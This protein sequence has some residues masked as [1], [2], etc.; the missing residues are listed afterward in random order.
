MRHLFWTAATLASAIVLGAASALAQSFPSRP[1]TMIVPR[2]WCAVPHYPQ[3]SRHAQ[4]Q[5]QRAGAAVDQQVLAA[6]R[7]RAHG[8]SRDELRQPARHRL[9]QRAVAHHR[10]PYPSADQ[11]WLQS[12]PRGFNFG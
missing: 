9:A 7:Q 4:V 3:P 5:D 10:R 2:R 6:P 8:S 11:Q 1:I 12:A